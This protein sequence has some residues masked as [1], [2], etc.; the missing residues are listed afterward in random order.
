MVY[1]YHFRL[2]Q[3][4][5]FEVDTPPQNRLS[6][7]YFLL[8]SLIDMS[9]K[10][11][12]GKHKQI[13]HHG[14][15]KLILEDSLQNLRLPI[16]WTSFRDMQAEGVIQDFEYDKS[17]ISSEKDEEIEG[18]NEEE[19]EEE[20]D[21]EKEEENEEE[22]EEETK[23]EIDEQSEQLEEEEKERDKDEKENGKE[24]MKQKEENRSK[25]QGKEV[26]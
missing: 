22:T 13:V 17:L 7:P 26:E 12:E 4:L 20:N 25:I 24:E 19:I 9:V 21:E 6:I 2:L 5:R 3:E 18:G 23:N 8:Q 15:I 11:Q 1:R 10:V 16:T 14:L